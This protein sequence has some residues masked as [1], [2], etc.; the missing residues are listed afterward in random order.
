MN[1]RDYARAGKYILFFGISALIYLA[2]MLFY[3]II[4][5]DTT[6]QAYVF[7][8]FYFTSL[9]SIY[10]YFKRLIYVEKMEREIEDHKKDFRDKNDGKKP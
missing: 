9:G 3:K 2:F 4:E 8:L 7:L 6:S 1:P 10:F 5:Y